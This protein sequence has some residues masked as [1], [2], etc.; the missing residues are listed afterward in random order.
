MA[1]IITNEM[2]RVL[3]ELGYTVAEAT[4]M[5]NEEIP[6]PEA[7]LKALGWTMGGPGLGLGGFYGDDYGLGGGGDPTLQMGASGS[8]AGAA[9]AVVPVIVLTVAMLQRVLGAAIGRQAFNFLKAM[10]GGAVRFPVNLWETIPSWVKTGLTLAGIT[11]GVPFLL[12]DD[13]DDTALVP[14]LPGGGAGIFIDPQNSG[15]VVGS[16][17]ANGVTFYRLWDGR[18]A[19][20]NKKGRWKVWRPKRPIVIMPTGASNLRTLLKADKVLD[21]QAKALD[22]ML[23][24]RTRRSTRANACAGCG[25]VRG[26]RQGCV[27]VN[28]K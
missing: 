24:R 14:A 3:R 25:L 17:E 28:V 11:V 5:A 1:I 7:A 4:A 26:H 8:A 20:Q 23:R 16:W 10:A 22:T 6:F 2:T 19:V 12:Q 18:I 9:A 21:R 15:Q 27:V 13:D